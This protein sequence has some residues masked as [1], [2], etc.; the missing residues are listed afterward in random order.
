MEHVK[1][2]GITLAVQAWPEA[3]PPPERTAV[4]FA[5]RE[6]FMARLRTV[7]MFAGRWNDSPTRH[8][9]YDGEPT[10]GGVRSKVARHAIEEEVANLVRTRLWVWHHRVQAPTLLL[11]APD[12]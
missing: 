3:P 6:A 2:N 12:G 10:A 4:G 11:R 9:T 7:P 5:S 1:T 8:F